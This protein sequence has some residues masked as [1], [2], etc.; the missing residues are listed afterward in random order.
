MQDNQLTQLQR[1]NDNLTTEIKIV[2]GP[3]IQGGRQRERI[4]RGN[5]VASLR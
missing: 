5:Y 2:R 4:D 3:A 1:S